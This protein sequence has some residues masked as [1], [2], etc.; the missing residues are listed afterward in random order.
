M[1][2]ACIIQYVS[3]PFAFVQSF[4][5]TVRW[6]N[7]VLSLFTE[8]NQQRVWTVHGWFAVIHCKDTA[9]DSLTFFLSFCLN[10]AWI[11][12]PAPCYQQEFPLPAE[13]K[14]QTNSCWW[15][16]SNIYMTPVC[17]FMG[18]L[19]FPGKSRTSANKQTWA[20]TSVTLTTKH[21]V[22]VRLEFLSDVGLAWE[23]L[24]F[25]AFGTIKIH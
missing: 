11:W 24:R 8:T 4:V 6:T 13:T 16:H 14:R 22:H 5:R 7:H 18:T 15:V 21:G 19:F 17:D 10:S 25:P 2:N 1:K 23:R 12:L 20:T 3:W 9:T